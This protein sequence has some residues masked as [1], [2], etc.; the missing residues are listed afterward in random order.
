[1]IQNWCGVSS[2]SIQKENINGFDKFVYERII[3]LIF[4]I[5]SLEQI[6]FDDATSI[7]LLK[8]LSKLLRITYLQLGGDFLVFLRN[9][10][11]SKLK[12]NDQEIQSFLMLIQS[13]NSKSFDNSFLTLMKNLY[14]K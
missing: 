12:L 2:S 8:D 9:Q 3:P 4:T 11:L 14:N 6:D 7:F 5:P 1:M 10:I 13:D